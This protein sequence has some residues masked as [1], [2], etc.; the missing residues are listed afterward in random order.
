MRFAVRNLIRNWRLGL[1]TVAVSAAAA[2]FLMAFC[3]SI[4][5]YRSKLQASYD[6]LEVTAEVVG[7]HAG[8]K[9]RL[10]EKTCQTI[11]DSGFVG[12]YSIM[13]EYRIEDYELL[14]GVNNL[15]IDPSLE[16]AL[17][18]VVWAEGYDIGF[19]QQ[20]DRACLVPSGWNVEP[21]AQLEI[22]FFDRVVP[23][24]VAGTYGTGKLG[25]YDVKIYYCPVSVLQQLYLDAE[26][27]FSY[28]AMEMDLCKL[29]KLDAF[30][31]Q[32]R[33]AGLNS[34]AAQLVIN[35]TQ[36][37]TVTAQLRRQVRLLQTLRPVLLALVA[38]IGFW[39]IFLLLKGRRREA[40]VM[41]SLGVKRHRVFC[42]LMLETA[43]QAVLGT[44]LGGGAAWVAFEK[45]VSHLTDL[46]LLLS[47]FTAGGACAVWQ[48]SGSNAFTVMKAKE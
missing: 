28:C 34:G 20:N 42:I 33:A 4:D 37:Q 1:I 16:R 17:S 18:S 39:L 3:H 27:E 35:D 30:K 31:K 25:P 41:R 14:R 7:A 45:T 11:L 21:G 43:I 29:E 9:P 36:L 15:Q 32:M 38:A 44:A 6:A 40:A 24:T 19:L 23:F 13:A 2:L 48:V 46:L 8:E 22:L 5:L 10:S 47:C 26:K 12:S